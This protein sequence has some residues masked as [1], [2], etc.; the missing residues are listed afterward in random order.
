VKTDRIVLCIILFFYAATDAW[1][2]GWIGHKWIEYHS[3]K[4]LSFY[5]L[6]IY[7]LW[8]DGWLKAENW[9]LLLWLAAGGFFFW[10]TFYMITR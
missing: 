7:I 5:I 3:I 8:K 9:K 2:D 4:W 6:P 10:E 1:R